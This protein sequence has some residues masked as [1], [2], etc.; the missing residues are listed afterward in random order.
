MTGT[1]RQKPEF[2]KIYTLEVAPYRPPGISFFG[3]DAPLVEVKP[4]RK[5]TLIPIFQKAMS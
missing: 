3:K 1:A 2:S 4:D 5:D